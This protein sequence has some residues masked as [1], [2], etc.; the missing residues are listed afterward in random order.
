[1]IEKSK[2]EAQKRVNQIENFR[3]E[4]SLLE[5]D[6]VVALE[7]AIPVNFQRSRNSKLQFPVDLY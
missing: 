6:G 5:R 1:M 4:L 3:I 2:T 7:A